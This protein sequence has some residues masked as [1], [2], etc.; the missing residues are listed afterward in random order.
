MFYASTAQNRLAGF[1]GVFDIF[2]ECEED[3]VLPSPHGG[4]AWLILQDSIYWLGCTA[5]YLEALVCCRGTC[6]WHFIQAG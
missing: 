2:K 3:G 1:V 6:D 5:S 4:L